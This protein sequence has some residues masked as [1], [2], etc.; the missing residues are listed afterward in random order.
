MDKKKYCFVPL[1]MLFLTLLPAIFL[2]LLSNSCFAITQEDY[3]SFLDSSLEFYQTKYNNIQNFNKM[4][5]LYSQ[6]QNYDSLSTTAYGAKTSGSSINFFNINNQNNYIKYSNIATNVNTST[7]Q[8]TSGG[9]TFTDIANNTTSLQPIYSTVS[10]DTVLENNNIY[11]VSLVPPNTITLVATKSG[12]KFTFHDNDQLQVT[13]TGDYEI[14]DFTFYVQRYIDNEWQD[15]SDSNDYY[16][17]VDF[18]NPYYVFWNNL[19]YYPAGIYRYSALYGNNPENA[20]YS[21]TFEIYSNIIDNSATG[22][23][24][25]NGDINIDIDTGKTVDNI[26]DFLGESPQTTESEI[27]DSFPQVQIEDPT[28]NFFA[29]VFSEIE[30]IFLTTEDKT[31]TFS[32]FTGNSYTIHS[33]DITVPSSPLKTLVGLSVDFGICYYILK[34]IRKTIEKVKKGSFEDIASEDITA[35]MV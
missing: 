20:Y 30:D 25:N 9:Y 16:Y 15:F 2:V 33:N 18:E 34:D 17:L 11:Y 32:L 24:D 35:N 10:G 4:Y 14:G 13:L 28:N 8:V 31:F 27:K 23:V 21:N 19:N 3:N 5:N 26:K 22:T 1:Y 6:Y 7:V 29:W 12:N